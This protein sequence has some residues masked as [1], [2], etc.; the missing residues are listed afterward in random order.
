MIDTYEEMPRAVRHMAESVK[1]DLKWFHPSPPHDHEALIVGG[2]PSLKTRIPLIK[3]RQRGGAHVLATN[4]AH[5]LLRSHGIVPEFVL[6]V[7][8]SEAIALYVDE[9]DETDTSVYL[10]ASICHPLVF[11]R[12]A[13]R[14]VA[15]WHPDIP[16]E[17][18]K[19]K[20]LLDERPEIA[21]AL[22]GG[23]NTG[24][25]RSLNVLFLAG[26]RTF[27]LYGMD[28]SYPKGGSDHAYVKPDGP[29]PEP[30]FFNWNGKEYCC[31]PWMV[32]QAAEF[33]F[34]YE[35]LTACGCKVVVHG[36]G[37]IPDVWK[38]LRMERK[39]AA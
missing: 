5:R 2:G 38:F 4:G 30:V 19:Q 11:D 39:K 12:L 16:A 1:R 32:R 18:E 35:Q 21:S 3:L 33:K 26:Y 25:L 20:A 13:G 34:Q 17:R 10:V 23:G 29:D 7:D 15:V 24:A 31:T 6:F 28:S 36:E 8:P 22:I 37:L 9:P 14:K 27:H